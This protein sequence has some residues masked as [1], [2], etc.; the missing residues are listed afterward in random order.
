MWPF[1]LWR[2]RFE[3]QKAA[4]FHGLEPA[5]IAAVMDR[6]SLGGEALNPPTRLGV[7]DNGHGR[8]LMQI[9][10]RAHTA[11]CESIEVW[12]NAELNVM[13]GT[14]ILAWGLKKTQGHLPGAVATYNTGWQRKDRSGVVIPWIRELY[15][16]NP[17]P[18]ILALD[19]FTTGHNYVDDV[20]RRYE[21]LK[22]TQFT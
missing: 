16:S 22:T 20:M 3:I 19:R 2:W 21:R 12:G 9:D 1:R 4:D 8:G 13:K 5:I 7:G 11:F 15:L 6:E 18:D 14:E 17:T 10:D